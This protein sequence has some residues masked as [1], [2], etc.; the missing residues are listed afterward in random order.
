MNKSVVGA[1][2]V[3]FAALAQSPPEDFVCPMD[4]DVRAAAPGLCRRC[5][6]RLV[7]NLPEMEEFQ[8]EVITRPKAIDAGKPVEME[9]QVLR[10]GSREAAADFVVVHEKLFHLFLV[11][12]DLRHFAH[13]HP[14]PAAD[15]RF[16]F[17]HV[18]PAPGAY[19]VVA[20]CFPRGGT[21]Q[22]LTRTLITRDAP[23]GELARVPKLEKDLAPQK[24]ENLT[25][26]LLTEPPQP[27][28]GKETLL[29]FRLRPGDGLEQYLG[30]WGH[31]LA[32]S[33]DLIDVVHDHPLYVTE[34]PQI[35]FNLIFPREGVYRV[36]V[37]FQRNGVVNTVAFNVRAN[38][39]R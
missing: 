13:E 6:M 4:K 15:G 25:V 20:D 32:A 9:F 23:V 31:M 19:R 24:G 17:R 39:L 35:Q 7:A 5:G 14:E 21:P 8:L 1:V 28:A 33:A 12:H 10:P 34:G 11:S 16:R 26:E 2:V 36:W 37:Q 27:L 22:F 38:A 18:F 3:F 30:A 29:F